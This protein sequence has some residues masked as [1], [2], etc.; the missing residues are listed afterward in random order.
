MKWFLDRIMM[1]SGEFHPSVPVDQHAA[2][3]QSLKLDVG[4]APLVEGRFNSYKSCIKFYEYAL[5]GAATIASRVLPYSLEC[6]TVVRNTTAAWADVLTE[7]ADS[8][9][10]LAA[11]QQHEWVMEYRNMERNVELWEAAYGVGEEIARSGE[12]MN[13]LTTAGV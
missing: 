8:D 7:A 3:I 11:K 4:L 13:E 2:R 6:P 1:I 12:P 9:Q 10:T 5:A